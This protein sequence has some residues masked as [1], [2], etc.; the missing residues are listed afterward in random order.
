MG[1]IYEHITYSKL[2]SIFRHTSVIVDLEKHP[3]ALTQVVP[4]FRTIKI[5]LFCRLH[6][7][8]AIL[9][10]KKHPSTSLSFECEVT[11][12]SPHVLLQFIKNA[13]FVLF[14]QQVPPSCFFSCFFMF[15]RSL[16]SMDWFC[17]EN[18]DRKPIRFFH[19]DHEAFL[20]I[21]VSLKP[22]HWWA[23]DQFSCRRDRTFG[24]FSQH[25]VLRHRHHTCELG[26]AH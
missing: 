14:Q 5:L 4:P 2:R 17:W 20:Y 10:E 18:L 21:I 12:F 13:F 19:E 1:L 9:A 26:W 3:A 15:L 16:D 6:R 8:S 23:F 11:V 24:S 7:L 22:I 25:F